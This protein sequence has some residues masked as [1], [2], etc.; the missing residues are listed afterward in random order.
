M[1]SCGHVPGSERQ[2]YAQGVLVER[3]RLGSDRTAHAKRSVR[4]TPTGNNDCGSVKLLTSVNLATVS[5][6][7]QWTAIAYQSLLH[8]NT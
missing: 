1:L 6:N 7:V 5:D 3:L 8:Q 4:L 2:V